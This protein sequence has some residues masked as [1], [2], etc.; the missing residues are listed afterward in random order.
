MFN[1]LEDSSVSAIRAS[2]RE[3]SQRADAK[4]PPGGGQFLLLGDSPCLGRVIALAALVRASRLRLQYRFLIRRFR[5]GDWSFPLQLRPWRRTGQLDLEQVSSLVHPRRFALEQRC[6]RGRA[7]ASRP[8]RSE[9]P[10]FFMCPRR[11]R[12]SHF[13]TFSASS[14]RCGN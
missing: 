10:V 11:P 7:F 4:R 8:H 9:Q 1:K 12:N 13:F 2:K 6:N 14:T 5:V 3:P